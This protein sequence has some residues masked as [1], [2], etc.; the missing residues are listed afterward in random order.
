MRH[1]VSFN[2]PTRNLGSADIEFF[3]ERAGKMFG[4]LA[5]S[6]GSIVWFQKNK[7]LGHKANWE[8]FDRDMQKY[9]RVEKR[10]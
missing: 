3:V 4:K 5:V 8:D 6:K 9:P 1:G 10:K 2:I 7:G